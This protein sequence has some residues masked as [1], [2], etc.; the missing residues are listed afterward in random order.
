MVATAVMGGASTWWERWWAVPVLDVR[1]NQCL[2]GG[3]GAWQEGDPDSGDDV[4]CHGLTGGEFRDWRLEKNL[5]LTWVND[6]IIGIRG[7]LFY[8]LKLTVETRWMGLVHPVHGLTVRFTQF[9][10]DFFFT[11]FCGLKQTC[12]VLGFIPTWFWLPR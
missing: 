3:A 12:L 11:R 9:K 10:A 2:T 6:K 1:E 8:F 4:L 7:F 5:A